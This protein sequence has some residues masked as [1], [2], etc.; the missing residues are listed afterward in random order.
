M[1]ARRE[2]VQTRMYTNNQI[3]RSCLSHGKIR[4]LSYLR[5][6]FEKSLYRGP[7]RIGSCF[8]VVYRALS[9]ILGS[10]EVGEYSRLRMGREKKGHTLFASA[11]GL[12]SMSTRHSI[13]LGS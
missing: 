1:P 3:P 12:M 6:I 5:K 8:E 11:S 13:A 4:T 10:K 7:N 2:V 9:V